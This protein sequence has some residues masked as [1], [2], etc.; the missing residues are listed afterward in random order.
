MQQTAGRW[1]GGKEGAK[2]GNGVMGS[3][4]ATGGRRLS[5]YEVKRDIPE[6]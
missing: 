4:Q 5:L 1:R 6:Q 2:P 3:E